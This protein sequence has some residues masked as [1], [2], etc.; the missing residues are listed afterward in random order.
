MLNQNVRKNLLQNLAVILTLKGGYYILPEKSSIT[1]IF[2][3]Q[4]AA[5][6]FEN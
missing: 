1:K 2:E 6:Y 3:I 5:R 4:N